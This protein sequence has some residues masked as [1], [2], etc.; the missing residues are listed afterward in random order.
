MGM[1]IEG[2]G[3]IRDFWSSLH[4]AGEAGTGTTQ[5]TGQDTD[6]QTPITGSESTSIT[7]V[8]A[9]QFLK[10]TVRFVGTSGGGESVTEMIWKTQSPELAGS[11]IT[12]TAMTYTTTA[13]L[14][15]QT[16]WYVRGRRG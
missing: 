12:F 1:L 4:T 8:T 9:D 15:S 14:T 7:T 10:K 2:L 3:K 5:E 6:L 11:R 13:D 16:R